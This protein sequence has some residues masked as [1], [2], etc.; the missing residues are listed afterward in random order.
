MFL[1]TSVAVTVAPG[2]AAPLESVM[3]PRRVP[4]TAWAEAVD[5]MVTM[6]ALMASA[7]RS[8]AYNARDTTDKVRGINRFLLMNIGDSGGGKVKVTGIAGR[9]YCG[10]TG[11][12][13]AGHKAPPY[14]V[15]QGSLE[16]EPEAHL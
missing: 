2:I 4:V 15:L 14:A 6:K 16:H 11:S 13:E 8:G 7:T 10:N 12:G 5:G 9:L 1:S 3:F